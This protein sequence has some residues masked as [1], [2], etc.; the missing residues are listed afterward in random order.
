MKMKRFVHYLIVASI[1]LALMS[2]GV[3]AQE[4]A[5]TEAISTPFIT[6]KKYPDN[7]FNTKEY[8]NGMEKGGHNLLIWR[9]P[10]VNLSKYSSVRLTEFG[11]RLLP[12]QNVFSYDSYV[13]V[14]NAVLKSSLTLPQKDSPDALLIEGAV[15]EC[16][17]GSRAARYL[18]GFGAGK[19]GC[20]A[21]CEI[22]EP[23]KSN[24]FIRIYTRD[25]G[26]TG[27]FGGNSVAMLNHIMTE[28][29]TRMATTLNTTVGL[30]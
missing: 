13:A 12:V 1:T 16:N 24:P 25:T 17:P 5:S 9:D 8:I 6:F 27:A 28:I 2:T 18:V 3:I 11:G 20:A 26:S 19:T 23:G 29:A 30:K 22:Y 10:A 14:F 21:V 7:A 4:K 15:V